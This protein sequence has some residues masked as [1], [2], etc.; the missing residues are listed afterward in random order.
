MG[1]VCSG[2]R[3]NLGINELGLVLRVQDTAEGVLTRPVLVGRDWADR[4]T[5][6]WEG[7]IPECEFIGPVWPDPRDPAREHVWPPAEY[8]PAWAG[9]WSPP[10]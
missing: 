7:A 5:D 3:G 2:P 8:T 4:C 6:D 1:G 9:M 10:F